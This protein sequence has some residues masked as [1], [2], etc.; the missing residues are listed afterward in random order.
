MARRD[1]KLL[2]SLNCNNDG[3]SVMDQEGSETSDRKNAEGVHALL[4]DEDNF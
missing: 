2:R 4:V 1:D 3:V